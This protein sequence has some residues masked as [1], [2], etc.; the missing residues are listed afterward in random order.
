MQV[1]DRFMLAAFNEDSLPSVLYIVKIA[2][3]CKQ[4]R[5]AHI[6]DLGGSLQMLPRVCLGRRY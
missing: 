5:R 3:R 4:A 1:A 6:P 2:H